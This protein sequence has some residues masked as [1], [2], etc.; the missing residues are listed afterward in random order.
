MGQRIHTTLDVGCPFL[1]MW[2]QELKASELQQFTHL[3]PNVPV[4]KGVDKECSL[5]S[6]AIPISAYSNQIPL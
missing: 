1:N 4:A 5:Q 2:I 3:N 6:I